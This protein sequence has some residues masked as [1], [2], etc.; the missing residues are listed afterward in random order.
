[1]NKKSLFL[2]L[3]TLMLWPATSALAQAEPEKPLGG[4]PAAGWTS[5]ARG[6]AVYQFDAELDNGT[7]FS[8]SRF[9]IEAG[10]GYS[11]TRRNSVASTIT[12]SPTTQ[13][14]R[15]M[16]SIHGTIFTASR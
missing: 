5:F 3:A 14:G 16:A 8:S 9:N 11:W 4:P 13:P 6:G 2:L 15:P 1:M 10:S 12:P 7:E